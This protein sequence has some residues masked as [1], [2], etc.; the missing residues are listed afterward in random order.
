MAVGL[1]AGWNFW[2]DG[3]A[4]YPLEDFGP[5]R[6]FELQYHLDDPSELA[7]FKL[8]ASVALASTAAGLALL[9]RRR[10]RRLAQESAS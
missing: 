3:I 6:V 1:H 8:T 9:V 5:A 10:D 2:I 7:A 4:F